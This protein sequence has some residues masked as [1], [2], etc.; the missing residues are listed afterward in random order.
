MAS[1]NNRFD[2]LMSDSESDCESQYI[3][4]K[5][6]YVSKRNHKNL[7]FAKAVV[8]EHINNAK[9]DNV[10]HTTTTSSSYLKP[11]TVVVSNGVKTNSLKKRTVFSYEDMKYEKVREQ[12]LIDDMYNCMSEDEFNEWYDEHLEEQRKLDISRGYIDDDEEYD[13]EEYDEDDYDY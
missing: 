2:A 13:D 9:K 4:M 7:N 3:P 5:K 8:K 10:K 1:Y 12:E 6:A 11:K